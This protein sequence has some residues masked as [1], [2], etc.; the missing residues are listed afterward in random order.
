MHVF[1]IAAVT[2]DGF[3][4]RRADDRSFNWTSIEDKRFYVEKIKSVDAIIMGSKTFATFKKH[5]RNSRWEI[6]TRQPEKFVNHKPDVIQA[7]G[8]NESP[9]QLIERLQAEGLKR[10]A[11]AG[12]ASIYSMFLEAGVVDKLYL[13]VEAT[14]FGQGITLFSQPLDVKLNLNQVMQLSAKTIVLEYDVAK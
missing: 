8:T 10:V 1:L 7:S 14:L 13:T 9:Q 12:G 5:P 6:Y 2:A 11:I 3:I 4:A